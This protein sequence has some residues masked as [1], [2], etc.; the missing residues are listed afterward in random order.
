MA[1]LAGVD[2]GDLPRRVTSAANE[3]GLKSE[4]V[5][6]AGLRGL[7]ERLEIPISLAVG[8]SEPGEPSPLSRQAT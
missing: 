2:L 5:D 1:P 7:L 4:G 3:L 6:I 8:G